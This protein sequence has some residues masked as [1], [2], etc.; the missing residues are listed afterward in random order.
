MLCVHREAVLAGDL[1]PSRF[2][3]HAALLLCGRITADGEALVA[4]HMASAHNHLAQFAVFKVVTK[5]IFCFKFSDG[6]C[7]N[8]DT[9][10]A[11]C[12]NLHIS[13]PLLKLNR[14]EP[15]QAQNIF[16]NNTCLVFLR[17]RE[18]ESGSY[19]IN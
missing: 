4:Q 17:L 8:S 6:C 7:F 12:T 16:L 19:L 5:K 18:V 9:I 13:P 1:F 11:P 2:A 3:H 15:Q 10:P 14:E